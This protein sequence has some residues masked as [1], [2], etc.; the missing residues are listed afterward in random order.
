MTDDDKQEKHSE[1]E[2]EEQLKTL[3]NELKAIGQK[4]MYTL[5]LI[6]RDFKGLKVRCKWDDAKFDDF[7]KDIPGYSKCMRNFYIALYELSMT[8][9]KIMYVDIS[10]FGIQALYKHFKALKDFIKRDSDW[11]S[12]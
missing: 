11:W 5:C 2:I 10:E 7:L 12:V 3:I 9:N 1:K 6:G 8:Y 4:T